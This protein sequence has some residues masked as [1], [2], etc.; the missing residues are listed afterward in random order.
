MLRDCFSLGLN[1]HSQAGAWERRNDVKGNDTIA[2]DETIKK[3]DISFIIKDNNLLITI[4]EYEKSV[5]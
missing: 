2:F 5:A 1:M 4:F 3:E